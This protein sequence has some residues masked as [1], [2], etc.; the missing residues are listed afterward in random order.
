MSTVNLLICA[1]TVLLFLLLIVLTGQVADCGRD[2]QETA[3]HIILVQQNAG[4]SPEP[5]EIL[6][7]LEETAFRHSRLLIWQ[8]VILVVLLLFML[9]VVLFYSRILLLPLRE[10][11]HRIRAGEK[12]PEQGVFEMRFLARSFNEFS[13]KSESSRRELAYS[14]SHD[15]LTGLYN[16]RAFEDFRKEL[17]ES[18][19]G[20]LFIDIDRFKEIN[21]ENGH[22]TGDAA[23][24]RVA[25][26]LKASFRTGD[27]V[28][29]F[30]GDEFCV[31]MAA[32]SSRLTGLVT[33]KIKEINAQLSVPEGDCP[34]LSISAGVAFGDRKNPTDDIFQDADTALYRVK[35]N[36]R[37]GCAF[38]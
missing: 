7:Q 15:A 18:T 28:C 29:R 37:S 9:F 35:Q 23:L 17:D 1:V 21:D 3:G 10:S 30:G 14:A 31:I 4:S 33:A 34:A 24:V 13:H 38:F 16:R 6:V 2:M 32:A 20:V 25:Q 12:I 27:F 22:Q 8:K 5:S 11:V 26:V 36:G 19:V